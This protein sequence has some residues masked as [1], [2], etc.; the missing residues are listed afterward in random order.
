MACCVF[1]PLIRIM[2]YRLTYQW[3]SSSA[4]YAQ[5][6]EDISRKKR[7]R[8]EESVEIG[9]TGY[10]CDAVNLGFVHPLGPQSWWGHLTYWSGVH[11]HLLKQLG[12]PR[13]HAEIP[14]KY[15][16]SMYSQLTKTL[17]STSTSIRLF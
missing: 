9:C 4:L 3:S 10:L 14:G 2:H 17:R 5:S 7:Q 6:G 15:T 16:Y 8:R 13:V 11:G 1:G 12:E